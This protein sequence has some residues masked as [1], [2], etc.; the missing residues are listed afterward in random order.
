MKLMSV[1]W[2]PDEEKSMISSADCAGSGH[3]PG[4]WHGR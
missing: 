3:A 4:F 2:D 1:S